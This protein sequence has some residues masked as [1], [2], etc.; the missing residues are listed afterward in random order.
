MKTWTKQQAL[1]HAILLLLLVVDFS[2][3]L[4]VL[5]HDDMLS[6]ATKDIYAD[7]FQFWLILLYG[8]IWFGSFPIIMLVIRLNQDQLQKMNIDRFYVVMLIT[9]G[10]IGLYSLPYNCFAGIALLSAIYILFDNKIRFGVADQNA[11]RMILLIASV[12]AGVMILLVGFFDTTKIDLLNTEHSVRHFLLEAIPFS[13]YEEVVY[14]GMLYMLL[15]DLGMSESKT[16]YI[17]AF[18]FWI[19]HINYLL[20]SAVSFWI[21]LPILSLI[22]GYIAYRS[23]SI[24]PSAIA[25]ILYNAM[26]GFTRLIF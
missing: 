19:S 23:K 25:H 18:L 15:K 17:Q 9:A 24:T 5:I 20:E 13:I 8:L 12:F 1:T 7:R 10:L 3:S 22:L 4:L 14:R 11:L 2:Q 6:P 26:V 21:I 16:F